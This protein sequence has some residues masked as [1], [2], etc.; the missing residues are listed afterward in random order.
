MECWIKNTSGSNGHYMGS[1][2]YDHNF[3]SAGGNPGTYGYWTM[4]N[5]NPGSS[6]TK[7]S[8]S[9]KGFG[10]ATGTFK[11]GSKYWTPQALFNYSGGGNCVISGWKVTKS[12]SSG[13]GLINVT[14]I[15]D[16]VRKALTDASSV[17]SLETF[18]VNKKSSSSILVVSGVLSC[19]QGY[20]GGSAI[21]IKYGSGAEQFVGTTTY[22]PSYGAAI[23]VKAV[24]AGH[25]TTGAQ[26]LVIRVSGPYRPCNILN[27]TSGDYPGYVNQ[28]SSDFV[29]EEIE[30]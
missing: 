28:T 21:G 10:T 5:Y 15:K 7:V 23:P 8:G 20:S 4:S 3:A 13:S 14:Y 1:I 26:S 27:P 17:V 6:W 9:I 25:T 30:P 18:T 2:D 24:I 19:F 29:I 11:I 22:V 12:G 16:N